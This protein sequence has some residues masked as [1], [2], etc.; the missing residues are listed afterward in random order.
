M[1]LV[2]THFFGGQGQKRSKFLNLEI[3]DLGTPCNAHSESKW[4]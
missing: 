3:F 1:L 2:F 4:P